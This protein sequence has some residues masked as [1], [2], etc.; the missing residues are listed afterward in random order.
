MALKLKVRQVFL[1]PFY[2]LEDELIPHLRV[3]DFFMETKYTHFL[4]VIS[5][6]GNIGHFFQL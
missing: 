2:D 4:Y 3:E 1:F 5:Y 6:F